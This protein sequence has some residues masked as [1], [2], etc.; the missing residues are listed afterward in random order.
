MLIDGEV[1]KME[2]WEVAEGQIFKDT[3][4]FEVKLG[5]EIEVEDYRIGNQRINDLMAEVERRYGNQNIVFIVKARRKTH[6]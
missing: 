6:E 4:T 1:T 3:G 2:G 5:G